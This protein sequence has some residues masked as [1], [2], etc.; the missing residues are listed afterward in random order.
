[1]QSTVNKNNTNL[2][3]P[4]DSILVEVDSG[5]E[6]CGL[7]FRVFFFSDKLFDFDIIQQF[8]SFTGVE[9]NYLYLSS[10]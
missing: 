7:K 4:I 8:I 5:F 10:V 1:M 9:I 6:P 3:V 2:V